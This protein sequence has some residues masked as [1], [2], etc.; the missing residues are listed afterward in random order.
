MVQSVSSAVPISKR[1]FLNS[2]VR[3]FR[4]AVCIQSLS[5]F[6]Y[7]GCLFHIG[8]HSQATRI[9]SRQLHRDYERS[10]LLSVYSDHLGIQKRGR[11]ERRRN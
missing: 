6:L 11:L 1:N 10:V 2:A 5:V 3:I 4:M 8:H 7:S 9:E